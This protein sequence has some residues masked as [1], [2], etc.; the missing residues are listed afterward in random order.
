[1]SAMHV[2]D[3]PGRMYIGTCELHCIGRG[4]SRSS[5]GKCDHLAEG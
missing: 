4:Q 3:T 5:S 2:D 1:M